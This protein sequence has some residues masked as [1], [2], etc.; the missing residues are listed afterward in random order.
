MKKIIA[1]LLT[2]IICLS[3]CACG[4]GNRVAIVGKWHSESADFTLMLNEDKTGT[5]EMGDNSQTIKWDYDSASHVLLINNE[6]GATIQQCTYMEDSDTI[7]GGGVTF[8]RVK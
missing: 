8:E 1:L 6:D 7:Y 5:L 4:G 2:A 3:L